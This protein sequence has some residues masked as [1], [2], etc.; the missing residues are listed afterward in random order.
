MPRPG[1]SLLGDLILSIRKKIPDPAPGNDP[2]MDGSAFGLNDLLVWINDAQTLIS[3]KVPIIQDWY[4]VPSITG[5]DVYPLPNYIGSIEQVWYD[6]L[7]C[8]AQ[9]EGDS[10]FA[11]HITGRA[12]WFAPHAI[13]AIPKL[14]VF[15]APARNGGASTTNG[16]TAVGATSV[17][18]TVPAG[19]P[20]QNQY[21]FAVITGGGNTE[22]IRYTSNDTTTGTLGNV[23]KGQGGTKDLAW[24]GGSTIKECNIYFNC[25]RQAVPLATTDDTLEIPRSLWPLIELYVLAQVRYAEQEH[26]VAMSMEQTFHKL[27]DDIA[28]K[29]QNKGL[30][31]TIQVKTI[32]VPPSLFMGKIYIP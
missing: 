31:Q 19:T 17:L 22:L 32:S 20:F 25:Y 27:A 7:Q 3:V 28:Q 16:S 30:R 2:T 5:Q 1:V 4:G 15:P 14:Y 13:H 10:L 9:S 29:A 23:L 11:S 18:Y 24:T 21:G 12:W 26:Q 8:G 6:N